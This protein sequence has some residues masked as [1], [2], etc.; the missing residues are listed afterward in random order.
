[1]I[2]LG[3]SATVVRA[4]ARRPLITAATDVRCDAENG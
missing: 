1:M 3:D 2:D 4:D